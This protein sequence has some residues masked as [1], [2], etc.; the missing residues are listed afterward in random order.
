MIDNEIIDTVL[1]QAA[2]DDN[3][4]EEKNDQLQKM[5]IKEG[6]MIREKYLAFL[7]KQ[8]CVSE[9]DLM[10]IYNIQKKKKKNT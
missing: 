1:N 8:S 6:L 2:D 4:E 5:Q 3:E 7:E 10:V 9:Q